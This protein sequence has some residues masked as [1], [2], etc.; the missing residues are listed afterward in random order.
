[1]QEANTNLVYVVDDEP[2]IRKL[3]TLA[4]KEYGFETQ[5]FS[6][7]DD[8]L[9]AVKRRLPDV[10]ILDWVMPAPDGLSICSR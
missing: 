6:N 9:K 4:L 10:I 2:N 3:T 5:E 7:G 1:M 8:L